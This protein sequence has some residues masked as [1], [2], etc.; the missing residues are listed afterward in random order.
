MKKLIVLFLIFS[1][2]YTAVSATGA[3]NGT[4]TETEITETAPTDTGGT[5]DLTETFLNI[6][7]WM[8]VIALALFLICTVIAIIYKKKKSE[9]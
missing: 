3:V 9:T 1:L 6:N 5:D 7:V 2:L 8:F 4:E